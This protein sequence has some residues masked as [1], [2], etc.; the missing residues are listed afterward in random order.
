V[1]P[2]SAQ[3]SAVPVTWEA[4][5]RSATEASAYVVKVFEFVFSVLDVVSNV[6]GSVLIDGQLIW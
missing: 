5:A 3:P 6:Q 1:A 4:Q 2:A